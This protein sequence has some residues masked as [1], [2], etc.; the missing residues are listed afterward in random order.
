MLYWYDGHKMQYNMKAV[1]SFDVQVVY[2]EM[3]GSIYKTK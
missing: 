3:L 2:P 1:V